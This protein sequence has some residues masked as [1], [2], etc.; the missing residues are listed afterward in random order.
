MW[1]YATS[2]V[3]GIALGVIIDRIVQYIKST[4]ELKC[5][6]VLEGCFGEPFYTNSFGVSD[7]Q[8]WSKARED[9]LK[10]GHQIIA[11]K[12]VPEQLS[13]LVE[14]LEIGKGIDN[15]LIMAVIN[16]TT[17]EM[18]ESMLVKYEKLSEDLEQLLEKGNGF[19]IIKG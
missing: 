14:G 2:L 16:E 11:V 18:T 12:A 15:Y 1:K 3:C 4:Q 17:K 19:V 5:S 9:L 7:V 6:K 13:K 8:D 10:S